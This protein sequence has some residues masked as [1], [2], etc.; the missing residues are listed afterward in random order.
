[1]IDQIQQ[2]LLPKSS[3]TQQSS[4]KRSHPGCLCVQLFLRLWELQDNFFLCSYYYRN[5]SLLI[6]RSFPSQK[7][8]YVLHYD[9]NSWN[10][11]KDLN[12]FSLNC[13]CITFYWLSR[14]V[15]HSGIEFGNQPTFITDQCSW[16]GSAFGLA[17]LF[18]HSRSFE[19]Y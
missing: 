12:L 18:S 16:F 3:L 5:D 4:L 14:L 1:M 6:S 7:I 9:L 15:Q 13:I 10:L 8:D 2:F 17:K 11:C 19:F